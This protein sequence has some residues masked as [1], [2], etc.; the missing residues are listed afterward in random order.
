MSAD[1][2]IA[3]RGDTGYSVRTFTG[4]PAVAPGL[5][6][7]HASSAG[8]ANADRLAAELEAV[9]LASGPTASCTKSSDSAIDPTLLNAFSEP[10][11]QKLLVLIVD[12]SLN[13]ESWFADWLQEKPDRSVLTVFKS[14]ASP[15]A[16]LPSDGLKDVN[17][18]F[19]KDSVT[20]AVPAV[21]S[22]SGLTLE[23]QRIFISYR[24]LETQPLAEQ[25][26]DALTHEG[27]DVFLDRFSIHPGINFQQRL[28]Q[29]LADKSMVLLLES[30]WIEQSFWTDHEIQFTKR[31]QLGLLALTM[32]DRAKPLKSIDV[33]QRIQLKSGH[34]KNPVPA[35]VVNPEFTAKGTPPPTYAQWGPLSDDK[36]REVV[37]S[38]KSVH[39]QA[40]FRRRRFIRS[41]V[42]ATLQHAGLS[43]S[44]TGSDGMIRVNA[45]GVNYALWL[46][47]RPPEM[48]DFYTTH[49]RLEPPTG[50][51]GVV[52]GP[53]AA[54]EP[55][56]MDKLVWLKTLCKM[57]CID[58]DDVPAATT[59]MKAGK[60]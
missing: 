14:G 23:D 32:P 57:A 28:T 60:L 2:V 17:A 21:L 56:R 37:Q 8:G 35:T 49:G 24:R 19:W 30:A 13:D 46:T 34:F 12:D 11:R 22:R 5:I 55:G 6:V 27:F 3:L 33:D 59:L 54:L 25:L 36:L 47:P 45:A 53:T 42:E 44:S 38:V 16:L 26:F 39:D 41:N 4:I 9:L 15:T 50:A 10:T 40:L 29:E 58:Q 52:I 43:T 48:L 51:R 7:I 20:E 31:Y 1:F 18:Q